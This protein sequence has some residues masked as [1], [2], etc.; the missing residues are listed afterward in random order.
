V[1]SFLADENI[2][3]KVIE[4]LVRIGIDIKTV[5]DTTPG[6]SDRDRIKLANR[7]GRIIITFDK[8]FGKL[9][10]KEKMSV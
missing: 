9:I 1:T 10:F 3:K 6:L 8:D 7:E 2:P 5:R 4:Y